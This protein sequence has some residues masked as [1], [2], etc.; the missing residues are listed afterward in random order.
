MMRFRF[1]LPKGYMFRKVRVVQKVRRRVH[2]PK[3]SQD[4][5]RYKEAA[6][7]LA[8]HRLAHFNMHYQFSFHRVAIRNQRTRWGSCSKKGNLNFNYR[9]IHLPPH[10]VDYI[11]VHELCHLREFN[12]AKGFWDL[13]AQT[14]PTHMQARTELKRVGIRFR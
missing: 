7:A 4:F 11:I 14:V 5:L 3:S 9:I 12:H 13:V 1:I 6:L 2:K 10:L 8:L